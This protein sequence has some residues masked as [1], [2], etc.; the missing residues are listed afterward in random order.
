MSTHNPQ[1]IVEALRNHLADP[2]TPLA[3]LLGAGAS[4]AVPKRQDQPDDKH[5]PLI[6]NINQLT[7]ACEGAACGEGDDFASAWIALSRECVLREEPPTVENILSRVI[8]KKE[9]VG[10]GENLC[11]LNRTQLTALEDVIRASIVSATAPPE[12]DIPDQIPHDAFAK[13]LKLS[14]RRRAIELFT[15]NYDVLIERSLE[16]VRAPM[17]DGFVGS[18]KPFFHSESLDD[19]QLLPPA[20]WIRL[21]KLHG[22]VNWEVEELGKEL[23]IIKGDYP[24]SGQTILPSYLKYQESRKMPYTAMIDRFSKALNQ[25]NSLLI[26]CGY[27]FGDQHLNSIIHTALDSRQTSNVICLRYGEIAPDDELIKT[28]IEKPNFTLLAQ[29]GGVISGRWGTWK[30]L[31]PLSGKTDNFM[32]FVFECDPAR[33]RP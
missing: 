5:E 31:Q 15:T 12:E 24:G 26:T 2:N 22:S 8:M 1:D 23:R 17:F 16:R 28:A 13:W 33:R 29:N 9:A 25:V 14:S 11:G 4:C 10:E 30:L 6:P 27:S 7:S 3:F 18:Y 19:T 20:E 32:Q 21:W